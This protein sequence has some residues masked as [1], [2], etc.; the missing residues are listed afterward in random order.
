MGYEIDSCTDDCYPN[1]TVLINK[2]NIHNEQELVD[3]EALISL[4]RASQLE[5]NP[6]V[7]AF[8]FSYYKEL[9][10]FLFGELYDWAGT[11]RKIEIS[12][13]GTR[14]YSFNELERIGNVIFSRLTTEHFAQH[15]KDLYCRKIAE[16][17]HDINMLHPFREGN[18]RTER[19]FF[20][21]LIRHHGYDI[22]F[23]ELDNDLLMLATIQA[24]N[25]VMDL[26]ERFFTEAITS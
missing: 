21:I 8:D 18:G 6:P 9:H 17:Y 19:L 20:I 22:N 25:G 7:G 12:K 4:I 23:S 5:L 10:N 14:F 15:R 16:Y 2:F 13:K 24:A 26:L 11:L 1:S 3:T